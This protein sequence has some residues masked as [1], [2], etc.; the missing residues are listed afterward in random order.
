MINV[1]SLEKAKERIEKLRSVKRHYDIEYWKN[2]D[3]SQSHDI[4]D[5]IKREFMGLLKHFP[6]FEL[7]EDSKLE[8]AYMNTFAAVIHKHKMMSLGKALSIPEFIE[9]LKP[10]RPKIKGYKNKSGVLEGKADGFAITVEYVDGKRTKAS[11]RGDGEIGDDITS[12]VALIPDIPVTLPDNFTGELGGEIYMRKSSLIKL[13]E[14]LVLEGKKPLK[15]VRNAAAGIGR[16][17]NVTEKNGQFLSFFC[18]RYI[19]EDHELETY[20]EG[21]DA[22]KA[23]GVKTVFHDLFGVYIEDMSLFTEE[24]ATKIFVD[25]E[26]KREDF[27]FDI[28]GVVIKLNDKMIQDELG[29]KLKV[30]N[31]AIAYKFPAEEKL[32]I[33]LNVEWDYGIKDG[34][35][36][37]MAIIEPVDIGGTTVKRPTLSNWDIVQKLGVRIGCTGKVSRHGDVIPY[38]EEV[39]HELDPE[40][41][42]DIKLPT[43]PHC[44]SQTIVVGAYVKCPNDEC[45][46]RIG[47]KAKSFVNAMDI[48]SLGGSTIDKLIESDKIVSIVDFY[49]LSISDIANLDKNGEKSAKKILANIEN[50]KNNPLWRVLSGLCI[51]LVGGSTSKALEKSIGSLERFK[52]IKFEELVAIDDVGNVAST[53]IVKW[54]ADADNQII[55]DELIALGIGNKIEIIEI[56]ENKLNGAKMAFTGT[57]NSWSR[58]GCEKV[59]KSSGGEV[60]GI[61]K[62]LQYL[63]IG[64]GAKDA[65]IKKATEL[66]AKIITESEFKEMIK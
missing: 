35:F 53:N 29:E 61:K 30:P 50:T 26:S 5:Q 56:K 1:L 47:G 24:E 59:I 65:K 36:T 32:T 58:T 13:N 45:P 49:K 17:K 31:W 37:P 28:D 40:D 44:D 60:W 39:I 55:L 23:M 62:E 54:L 43:C 48:D 57:L 38:F 25:I 7:P 11:T 34:R 4:Y 42:I 3:N 33:V 18:Y 14:K 63:L 46:G 12:T 22:A 20:M 21:M 8:S 16:K 19:N 15:N 51:K 6:Q 9:W 64:E 66:G 27:D 10:L 2:D 52:N 41:A